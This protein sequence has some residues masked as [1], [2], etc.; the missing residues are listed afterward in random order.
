MTGRL[1]RVNGA[2]L[3][4][5]GIGDPG[6]PAIL[7]VNGASGQS[8]W[9]RDEFCA[10]LVSAGRYVIRFD[11]RDTGPSTC[12]DFASRPYK[13]SDLARDAVGILDSD[14]GEW[15]LHFHLHT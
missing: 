5:S 4:T 7:L 12:F 10:A 2:E 6:S 8:I 13:I 1:V 15:V 9:W 14:T 11:H 3:W